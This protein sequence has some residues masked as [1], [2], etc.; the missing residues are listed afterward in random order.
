MALDSLQYFF[1]RVPRL[2]YV[3]PP[4]CEMEFSS[5][6]F[7]TIIL[8]PHARK[9]GPTGLEFF[10]QDGRIFLRW[11]NYPGAICFSIY[12][13][14]DELDPF[15]DYHLVAECVQ[16]PADIDSFG[17]GVYRISA[18]TIEGET[19]FSDPITVTVGP[20]ACI[21]TPGPLAPSGL[22]PFEIEDEVEW[23]NVLVVYPFVNRMDG[24][25]TFSQTLEEDYPPGHYDVAYITGM[26]EYPANS[27]VV[28]LASLADVFQPGPLTLDGNILAGSTYIVDTQVD[29]PNNTGFGTGAPDVPTAE[30]IFQTHFNTIGATRRFKHRQ[31]HEN[32]G[33]DIEFL[34]QFAGP[35]PM[36][37][38]MTF[39]LVQVDGLIQQPRGVRISNWAVV[40][41]SFPSDV[42]LNWNGELPVRSD[43]TQTTCVYSAAPNGN[44]GGAT[45]YYIQDHPTSSNGCG[46]RLDIYG[47]A[48]ALVWKGL[49][50]FDETGEGD[51]F[52]SVDSPTLTPLCL[53]IEEIP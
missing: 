25:N 40:K 35:L 38:N 34:F 49:K 43:Y 37:D 22:T 7:P 50:K 19:T 18:I 9:V 53:H 14:V 15:G 47:V 33:G 24:F 32:L 12:K 44:F 46:W 5:S 27:Y 11:N 1:Q 29:D 45:L 6:A 28:T 4:I 39:Q 42:F 21:E 31:R 26:F 30:A 16:S 10:V 41:A 52:R 48:S 17:P 23:E 3:S 2:N 20:S 8:N 13:A 51:F 36:N